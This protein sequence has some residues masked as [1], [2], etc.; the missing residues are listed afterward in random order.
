MPDHLFLS[1]IKH[2]G[3]TTTA[4]HLSHLSHLP[5]VDLDQLIEQAITPYPTIRDF[6]R[7]EGQVAFSALEYKTLSTFLSAANE[8]YIIA[9]GG[10]ACDNGPLME[11]VGQHGKLIYLIVDEETLYERIAR[12]G[13]PPFLDHAN[14]RTSFA[15]LYARRHER[16]S[17]SADLL[18][19]L[20]V[21]L[22]ADE[23]ALYVWQTVMGGT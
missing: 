22:S 17:K 10:G 6:Y 5:W 11:L 2:S 14:P 1:G 8:P 7:A 23:I 18:I 12:T 3:K 19:Q 16:Y 21:S 15:E 9:L 13:I 20:P 4:R